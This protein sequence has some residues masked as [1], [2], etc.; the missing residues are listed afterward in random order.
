VFRAPACLALVAT[1]GSDGAAVVEFARG[2]FKC[3]LC[4]LWK[5]ACFKASVEPKVPSRSVREA[6]P[7]AKG[8]EVTAAKT[9]IQELESE[10]ARLEKA[11][12][13]AVG[14]SSHAAD[15]E[16]DGG[17]VTAPTDATA[18]MEKTDGCKR[19]QEIEEK[20]QTLSHRVKLGEK[21]VSAM[22][23]LVQS[24]IMDIKKLEEQVLEAEIS[25]HMHGLEV[26]VEEL[27][28]LLASDGV[29]A[30]EGVTLARALATVIPWALRTAA[31]GGQSAA[32]SGLAAAEVPRAAAPVDWGKA[33]TANAD[34]AWEAE[35]REG[36]ED[37][38]E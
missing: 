28:D 20:L 21:K 29:G 12:A 37:I 34:E 4:R 32:G 36:L 23:E 15:M 33:A 18:E 19:D 26:D 7:W 3:V 31:G 17:G 35:L 13:S 25:A 22:R 38:F 11:S 5:S 24:N 14:G 27:G 8:K 9:R 10:V 2:D 6:P 1:A 16:V 30:E